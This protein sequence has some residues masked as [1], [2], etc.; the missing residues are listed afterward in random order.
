MMAGGYDRGHLAPA[1]DN[2]AS[3]A[4]MAETFSL[5][6]ISPQVGP[7]FNRCV[8]ICI[9]IAS[10]DDRWAN[11]CPPMMPIVASACIYKPH[12]QK[13]CRDYWARFEKFVRDLTKACESVFI[14]SGPLF[15]PRRKEGSRN[16]RAAWVMGYDLIGENP[17][18]LVAVP[19]HFYKVSGWSD[20]CVVSFA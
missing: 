13:T 3:A 20:M 9:C 7:G 1:A 6:N 18:G 16:P 4:A 5:A 11:R 17:T 12:I 19:T 14:V 10:L 15:L 8:S 2:R